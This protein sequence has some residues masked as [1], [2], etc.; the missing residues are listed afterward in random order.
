M[1]PRALAQAVCQPLGD[2]PRPFPPKCEGARIRL[3]HQA[4]LVSAFFFEVHAIVPLGWNADETAFA[5]A[6]GDCDSPS[7]TLT[8]DNEFT[9]LPPDTLSRGFTILSLAF[10]NG[11]YD[12]LSPDFRYVAVGKEPSARSDRWDAIDVVEVAGGRVARTVPVREPSGAAVGP[13]GWGWTR[14][15]RFAWSP[16][17]GFDFEHG[18]IIAGGGDGEVWLLDVE[19]GATERL[20]ARA[21]AA[22]RSRPTSPTVDDPEFGVS[23][24]GGADLVQWCSVLLD[25]EAVGAG[26]WAEAIGFV[27]LD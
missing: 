10:V 4:A 15:G 24:P 26:R 7:G 19:T 17:N 16:G 6:C 5:I 20:S 2:A 23:C 13:S 27:A 8:L 12:A 18:R 1:P 14:D 11:D 3:E 9:A 22:R 25:G 21:Y